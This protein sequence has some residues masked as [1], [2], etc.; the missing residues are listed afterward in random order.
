VW[1]IVF[2]FSAQVARAQWTPAK[3]LTWNSGFSYFPTIAVDSTGNLHVVWQDDTPGNPE[4]FYK[5]GTDAGSVW[6][7]GKS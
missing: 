6:A 2:S 3:R 7:A 4:I 1:V 5:K